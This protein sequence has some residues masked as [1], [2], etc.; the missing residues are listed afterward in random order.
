VARQTRRAACQGQGP[1][2]TVALTAHRGFPFHQE[3]GRLQGREGKEV[4]GLGVGGEGPPAESVGS[5]SAEGAGGR[6]RGKD[7]ALELS[8]SLRGRALGLMNW[9]SWLQPTV[10]QAPEAAAPLY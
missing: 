3:R 6:Q 2:W 8:R 9:D 1:P 7:R 5:V 4:H 10:H